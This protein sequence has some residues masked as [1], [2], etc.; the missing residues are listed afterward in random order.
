MKESKNQYKGENPRNDRFIAAVIMPI[1]RK[2]MT[3]TLIS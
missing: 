1:T 2:T 3:S